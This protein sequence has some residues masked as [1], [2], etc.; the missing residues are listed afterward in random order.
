MKTHILCLGDSN[1]HGYCADQAD[2]ADG[3]SRFNEDERWTKLLQKFLG[4]E[5]LVIEEGLGGRT[6]CFQDPLFE[7]LN[8]LNYITPCLKSHEPIDLLV[9]MLG[10][11]DTKDR[12]SA[13]G[14]CIAQGMARR[15]KKAIDTPCWGEKSPNILVIAPPPIEEGVLTSPVAATMGNGCVKRSRELARYYEEQCRLLGVHFLD[16]GMLGCEMNQVDYVHL[17]RNGHLTLANALNRWVQTH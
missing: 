4:D 16:A 6:T 15:V 8:A 17:T 13:S 5:Y 11:N 10:T 1:T 9:I 2:S 12:F 14:A 3:G 7:G